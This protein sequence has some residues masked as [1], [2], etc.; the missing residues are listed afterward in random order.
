MRYPKTR[1]GRVWVDQHFAHLRTF[2]ESGRSNGEALREAARALQH[3]LERDPDYAPETR[4]LAT[5]FVMANWN[6]GWPD[7]IVDVVRTGCDADLCAPELRT[8]PVPTALLH[9]FCAE[10]RRIDGDRL[11]GMDSLDRALRRLEDAP[12]DDL[13]ARLVRGRAHLLRGELQEIG[14]EM[15]QARKAFQEVRDALGP[16]VSS[17]DALEA[18]A[19]QWIRQVFGPE[20]SSI[21]GQTQGLGAMALH[22]F[23]DS[24]VRA[25]MGAL[26][27]GTGTPERAE[28]DELRAAVEVNGLGTAVNPLLTL[29][30]LSR[31]APDDAK[32]LGAFLAESSA[33]A[34]GR[35]AAKGMLQ[36]LDPELL[37][38]VNRAAAS[39]ADID[40]MQRLWTVVTELAVGRG[41]ESRGELAAANKTLHALTNRAIREA[42][43][44]VGKALVL[45]HYVRFLCTYSSDRKENDGLVG[46]FCTLLEAAW[47]TDREA[48]LDLR[49]R[50]QFDEIVAAVATYFLLAPEGVP[51]G[52]ARRVV[53]VLLDLLR[54]RE[55]PPVLSLSDE[56][57]FDTPSQEV[58]EGFKSIADTLDRIVTA[59]GSASDTVAVITH[60]ASPAG[61]LMI[62]ASQAGLS[63][64]KLGKTFAEAAASLEDAA[65][66]ALLQAGAGLASGDADP[67]AA[68]AR[69]A[70]MSLAA[71]VREAIAGAKV[72]LLVPDYR[73]KAPLLPWEFLHD[74]EDYLLNRKVL[75]RFGSLK[76]L[77][78]TLDMPVSHAATRHALVVS[79]SDA[80][81]QRPLRTAAPECTQVRI[82]LRAAGFDAPDITESRL[83]AAF[84]TDRLGWID[85]LHVAAHGES[86]AGTEYLALPN[87]R[88]LSV[89]QLLARRQ[90]SMPFVYLNT[91]QLGLTR[92]LGGGQS[93]G[94]AFTL[95]ELGAP[96]VMANTADVL[97]DVATELATAF[98]E[99]AL[100]QPVTTHPALVARVVL[101]GD[102]LSSFVERAGAR[103]E[104][105][106][107]SQF[108]DAYFDGRT[109]H[110]R[111]KT[112]RDPELL[113]QL[114]SGGMR[115]RAAR[116]LI[117]GF[118]KLQPGESDLE[119]QL[120][121]IAH[122]IAL[123]DEL[124]H[125]A[126][127]A[128]MRYVRA[129]L[130]ME[131]GDGERERSWMRDAIVH[132]GMLPT[133]NSTWDNA[134]ATLRAELRK[135]TLRDRGLEVRHHEPADE[136]GVLETVMAIKLATEQAQEE[137]L[138]PVVP[139]ENEEGLN[140]ILWNAVVAGHPNR[141]EDTIEASAY[142]GIVARKLVARGFVAQQAAPVAH[143]MLTGLLWWLWSS[144]NT[145][146]LD[147][148]MVEGQ[149]GT[150]RVML[151]DLAG[152]N[153]LEGSEPWRQELRSF[154]GDVDTVLSAL[155]KVR[156]EQA[157]LEIPKRMT[158]LQAQAEALLARIAEASPGALSGAAAYLTGVVAV[159]NVFTPLEGQ[160]DM[161]KHM[162]A[163][164][165]ALSGSNEGRF[166]QY[167]A[168]GF[169]A[170]RTREPDELARWRSGAVV[171]QPP[172]SRRVGPLPEKGAR[173]TR[174]AR[175]GRK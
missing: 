129:S 162:T 120:V 159:K 107:A 17:R 13:V 2:L 164:V 132:L 61:E 75:A 29:P 171:S 149:T 111:A 161:H 52:D 117:A 169:E 73:S 156:W 148:A 101:Y 154:A 11:R 34:T 71:G 151:D 105:D 36:G 58:S 46:L 35:L 103:P 3:L 53:S 160:D 85:V 145:S 96:A 31:L 147:P 80:I 64:H 30:A 57:P 130:A 55:M 14:Q 116:Q 123:A 99:E 95:A 104:G 110:A 137:E 56:L 163:V 4:Q 119:A 88:R 50:T 140:D 94:L 150:L 59:L 70:W 121:E 112:L 155:E 157:Y 118:A 146:Y 92:Y 37:A 133:S 97:D 89:D 128:M 93:R 16:I 100:S 6:A 172:T 49:F 51:E 19:V 43:S 102:P 54:V 15:V 25:L 135:R 9:I 47:R 33:S 21:A 7:I 167:L 1:S 28:I 12:A 76:H 60:D 158:A 142:A 170:I 78:C 62:L 69:H 114:L 127:M 174:A 77:A 165:D 108:L 98:Y 44:A 67:L 125:P 38:M 175:R 79:A 23:A 18:I 168:K 131:R 5:Q 91:C 87:G 83:A 72:V 115:A 84:F 66:L 63:V 41:L 24:H 10:A 86:L 126:A 113:G 26:R 122:A 153:P 32:S 20:D 173:K 134:L 27:T 138:S 8:V 82:G 45:G 141:F 144:Q 136:T 139:R 166:M 124:R 109:E 152:S 48:F 39:G 81:P 40:L 143:P 106:G 74:G 22:Q 90:R 65:E 68:A 42:G